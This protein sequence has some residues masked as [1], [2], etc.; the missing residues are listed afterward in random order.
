MLES[1]L[2]LH[3]DNFIYFRQYIEEPE[4]INGLAAYGSEEN[5]REVKEGDKFLSIISKN[6][7]RSRAPCLYIVLLKQS[8]GIWTVSTYWKMNSSVNDP[9]I[10]VRNH[11]I[12]SQS[13]VALRSY[14]SMH[15]GDNNLYTRVGFPLGGENGWAILNLFAECHQNTDLQRFQCFDISGAYLAFMNKL[16]GKRSVKS[17][18]TSTLVQRLSE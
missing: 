9:I 15:V 12:T 7:S 13:T 4:T 2:G 18:T 16:I 11:S 6:I 14:R 17:L 10:H 8:R 1:V 3:K 5:K